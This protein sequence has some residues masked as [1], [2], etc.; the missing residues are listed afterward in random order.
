MKDNL[1]DIAYQFWVLLVSGVAGSFL[2]TIHGP[3]ELSVKARAIQGIS[4]VLAA[5]FLG[6]VV[7]RFIS[8]LFGLE[9][10]IETLLASGFIVGR[11]SEEL[12][13]AIQKRIVVK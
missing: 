12:I 1:H 6:G 7:S 4:G 11:A 5:V 3:Q 13:A 10:G 2:K 9:V 8:G